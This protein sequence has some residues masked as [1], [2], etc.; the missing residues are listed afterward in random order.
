M[1]EHQEQVAVIDWFRLAYPKLMLFAIPN[2]GA[3]H[4]VTAVNLKREG[5]IS[6]VADMFL[7]Y[8]AFPFH[9]LFIEMKAKGGKVSPA[10]ASF[11]SAAKDNGYQAVVC[12]GFDEAKENINSY[13][14]NK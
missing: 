2:G 10:Q 4:I 5:V 6:G 1:S 8:A 7:M 11:M 14:Q 9:G 12:Y 3:R 13:L